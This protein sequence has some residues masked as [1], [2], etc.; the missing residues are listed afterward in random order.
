MNLN[1]SPKQTKM[2]VGAVIVLG[3]V[4]Y[5]SGRGGAPAPAEESPSP[6]PSPTAT[7]KPRT[8]PKP[9]ATGS[10]TTSAGGTYACAGGKSFTLSVKADGTARVTGSDSSNG[11]IL[12]KTTGLGIWTS[13]D[14]RTSV[15]ETA[16]YTILLENFVTTRDACHLKK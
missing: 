6:T 10:E 5:I 4:V 2:L 15:R 13:D 3:L 1:L 12:R 14:G 8:T 16:G 7:A 9:T 11:K